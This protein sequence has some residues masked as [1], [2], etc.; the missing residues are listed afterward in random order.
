MSGRRGQ[1]LYDWW[2]R[3][4]ELLDGLYDAVFLG[5]QAQ[6]RAKSVDALALSPGDTV[7]ELG[8]GD[9]RSLHRLRTR[10]G[11]RGRVVALDYS[12]GMARRT[13]ELVREAGWANV[14]VLRADASRLPLA[15]PVDAVYA[16]M[17]ASA[18]ADPDAVAREARRLLR[19]GG[20]MAVLDARPFGE[21]WTALNRVVVPVSRWATDWNPDAD[22]TGALA[23][24]FGEVDLDTHV[25]G[26]V[27]V[28]SA[29]TDGP[30]DDPATGP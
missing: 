15:G 29:R 21:P 26:T 6:L 12:E 28:A 27:F 7:L 22:V 9:G 11:P 16:S 23:A 25:W 10:V 24:G 2:S 20:R 8:C 19:S 5:R 4:G 14:H 1:R 3:H 18:M 13:S 30:C 17:A